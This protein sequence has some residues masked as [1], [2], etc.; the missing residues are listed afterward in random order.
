MSFTKQVYTSGQTNISA[1]NMN[2]IQDEII[3]L[4]AQPTYTYSEIETMISNKIAE[5]PIISDATQSASGLMSSSDKTKLD[6]VGDYVVSQGVTSN[7]TWRKWNSGIAECWKLHTDTGVKIQ[8]AWG[9]IY[10]SATTY[11]GISYPSGLFSAV[12]C[13][14]IT[15]NGSSDSRTTLGLEVGGVGTAAKTP[16]W[17]YTR[18]TQNN[19][20]QTI[21]VAIYA[22]GKWK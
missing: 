5:Q 11:G 1:S 9:S 4:G 7:F 2:D 3:R 15:S 21:N 22:I 13:C 18:A 14:T 16:F 20:G 19:S 10:E 6:A 8:T 12:P 17:N